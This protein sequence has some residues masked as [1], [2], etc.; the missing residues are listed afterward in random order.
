MHALLE[1]PHSRRTILN[2]LVTA[3][4]AAGLAGAVKKAQ[5][6]VQAANLNGMI[7]L[8]AMPPIPTMARVTRVGEVRD[9]K[10]YNPNT[11]EALNTVFYANGSY[12]PQSL[13][14]LNHFMRDFHE[15]APHVMDPSL[16]TLLHD[17]QRVFDNR[18]VHILSAY[19]TRRTNDRLVRGHITN[20]KDSF[21]IKGMAIDLRIPGIPTN[22]L[23]DVAKIL[24]VGGV[25]FYP[26]AHFIHIDTGP[27]R[28]W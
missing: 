28:F 26:W 25:G 27:V 15:N 22:A 4:F 6:P 10:L 7:T 18:Q 5:V 14:H 21:H 11:H 23:R 16:L 8:P 12:N 9:L 24:N 1:K 19:R 2:G 13:Q 17:M 3:G 20:A